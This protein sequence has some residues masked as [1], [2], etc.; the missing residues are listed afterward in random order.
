MPNK[1]LAFIKFA[2]SVHTIDAYEMFNDKALDGC[3]LHVIRLDN[4]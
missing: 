4:N 2:Q 3:I 1:N